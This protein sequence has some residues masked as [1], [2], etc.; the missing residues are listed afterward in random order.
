[1]LFIKLQLKRHVIDVPGDDVKIKIYFTRK[2]IRS[3]P[4][5]WPFYY[6][7]QQPNKTLFLFQNN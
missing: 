7:H 6:K 5:P 2:H 1:M 3:V 4:I